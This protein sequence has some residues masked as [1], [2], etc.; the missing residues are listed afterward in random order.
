MVCVGDGHHLGVPAIC[1]ALMDWMLQPP[2]TSGTIFWLWELM[3]TLSS[4]LK[5]SLSIPFDVCFVLPV[6]DSP[7]WPSI[8]D[9]RDLPAGPQRW[10]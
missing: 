1:G 2:P 7:G 6:L 5:W 9:H 10:Y 8:P 4:S 3:P